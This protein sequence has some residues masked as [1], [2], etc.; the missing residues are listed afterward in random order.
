MSSSSSSGADWTPVPP[1]GCGCPYYRAVKMEWQTHPMSAGNQFLINTGKTLLAPM[2]FGASFWGTADTAH[3]A[4]LVYFVC[5][6]CGNVYRRTY[7]LFPCGKKCRWGYYG[8]Y[9]KLWR[10]TKLRVS[11]EGV[12]DV[13]RRMWKN[14]SLIDAACDDWAGDFYHLV[15]DKANEEAAERARLYIDLLGEARMCE[16]APGLVRLTKIYVPRE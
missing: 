3:H 10:D 16:I 7:D 13:F 14:Y 9:Y 2:S 15:N 12:E 5:G 6:K 4:V 8:Y 11:Y 1:C